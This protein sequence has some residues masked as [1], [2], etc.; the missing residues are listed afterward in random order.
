MLLWAGYGGRISLDSLCRALGLP[1]PKEG[2]MDGAKVF[3]AWQAG[4]HADI[5]AYNLKDAQAV[6]AVWHRL[7]MSGAV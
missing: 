7:Q 5:A 3:D 1:S 2:G 4:Q 6:A